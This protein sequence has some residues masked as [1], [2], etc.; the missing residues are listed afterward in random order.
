MLEGGSVQD[1]P[2]AIS[3]SQTPPP[4]S[5]QNK[6]G[7]PPSFLEL[8][9]TS[10]GNRRTIAPDWCPSHQSC[11]NLRTHREPMDARRNLHHG[12]YRSYS[13]RS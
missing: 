1:T 8:N 13:K 4:H 2:P 12:D 5:Q 7:V 10:S 3:E 9:K 11:N 6:D